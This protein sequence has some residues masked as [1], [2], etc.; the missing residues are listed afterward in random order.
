[1]SHLY[2]GRIEDL[3]GSREQA[4]L[5]YKESLAAGDTTPGSREAA[6]KGLKES[7]AAPNK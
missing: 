1:M 5:H 3:F 6:E 7:F 4:I 2:L